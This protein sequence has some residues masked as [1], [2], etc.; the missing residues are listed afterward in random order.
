M[1]K[2]SPTEDQPGKE[3][4]NGP[5]AEGAASPGSAPATPGAARAA[6]QAQLQVLAQ[7]VKDLSFENPAAPQSLQGPGQNPQLKVGV[8]VGAEP[9]GDDNYEVTLQVE[10]HASNDRGVIYN[11]ELLYGGLFRL[12]NIPQN[13]LQPVLFI[14]CPTLIFPF[15][16]RVLADVTRDGGFPPLMLDPI[17]FGRL[18]AENLARAEANQAIKN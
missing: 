6:Q 13:L 15:M 17:D 10:V 3:S 4:G 14:D 2:K 8:N 18:F 16:R 11:V 9:R 7:Y 5:E 12:R 1:A